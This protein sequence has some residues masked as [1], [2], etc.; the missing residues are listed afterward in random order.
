MKL[1]PFLLVFMCLIAQSAMAQDWAGSAT[2]D[3]DARYLTEGPLLIQNVTYLDGRGN[4]PKHMRD[5]L[6]TSGKINRIAS[7]STIDSLPENTHVINAKGMTAMPGFIDLHLHVGA[8]AFDVDS[9]SPGN[10]PTKDDIQVTLNALLYSGVTTILDMG[11]DHDMIVG[12]RDA[13]AA[14]Y[15]PG[16]KIV[17]VGEIIPRLQTVKG[18]ANMTSPEVKAE[19][20]ELLDKRQAA[21]IEIVKIYGGFSN[22][23]ARHLTNAAHQR[24]MR[25]VADMWC[26][27]LGRST[28]EAT[29]VDAFAHGACSPLPES[30]AAWMAAHHK[31]A[32]MTL[33]AFDYMGSHRAY[34]DYET[35]AFLKDPLV[36]GP[37]GTALVE[38]YYDK[39]FAVREWVNVGHES[40]FQQQLFGDLTHMLPDTKITVKRLFNAGVLIGLGTDA[41]WPPG[42]WPG[43]SFHNEMLL[44]VEAGIPEQKVIQMATYNGARI[45]KMEDE[46]GS[47]EAGKVADIVL[48]KGSP[49]ENINNTRNITYV[50]QAGRIV[51]RK[52]LTKK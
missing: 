11:N 9:N 41:V 23:E 52:A 46:R 36:V 29:N 3:H 47:I 10:E 24:G 25:V 17:T 51:N 1:H 33:T 37:H 8:T 16:P 27:N 22:W 15:I 48:V 5:I 45:L 32:M 20:N 40:F 28:F 34:K 7:T 49:V 14:G 18:T 21:G 31:F 12:L 19:I 26:S 30:E 6:I 42:N 50:L 4:L 2:S 13:R 35:K 38:D 44:H 39:F 43:E